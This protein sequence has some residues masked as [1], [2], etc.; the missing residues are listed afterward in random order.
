MS[1]INLKDAEILRE[2]GWD[3][4][5]SIAIREVLDPLHNEFEVNPGVEHWSKFIDSFKSRI[6]DI[7]SSVNPRSFAI[8]TK[9]HESAHSDFSAFPQRATWHEAEKYI[10]TKLNFVR[11]VM[12]LFST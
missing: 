6:G 10:R 8:F 2:Q 3:N 4:D 12:G 5:S 9:I 11:F 1:D 7:E